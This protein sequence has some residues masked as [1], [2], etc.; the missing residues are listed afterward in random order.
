MASRVDTYCDAILAQNITGSVLAACQVVELKS[1]LN[2][3]FGDWE[4]FNMVL[5]KMRRNSH[6]GQGKHRSV[7]ESRGGTTREQDSSSG[8]VVTTTAAEVAVVSKRPNLAENQVPMTLCIYFLELE[9]QIAL[10]LTRPFL[11][12][13]AV[14]K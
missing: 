6:G 9:M 10:A 13:G 14:Q 12:L 5:A 2:M 11:V 7:S 1:V 8:A 3:S 4:I